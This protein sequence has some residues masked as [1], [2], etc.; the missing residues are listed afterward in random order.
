MTTAADKSR[1]AGGAGAGDRAQINLVAGLRLAP[2]A[3]AVVGDPDELVVYE[4]DG[5]T[6]SRA[7]PLAVVFPQTTEQVVTAVR[8]CN[9][10]KVAIM[11]RGSGTGLTGGIVA[12]VPGVQI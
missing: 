12:V 6:V 9:Q 2:C 8:I 11:P 3:G 5:F 4:C 7:K 1:G 10:H